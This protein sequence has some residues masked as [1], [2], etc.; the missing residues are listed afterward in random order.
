MIDFR[1]IV[2]VIGTLITIVALAMVI[3]A[4]VDY[5]VDHPD[6]QVFAVS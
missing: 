3:P 6:W 2:F 4:M 5:A 1:P